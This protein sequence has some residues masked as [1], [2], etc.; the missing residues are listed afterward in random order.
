M[1]ISKRQ[2]LVDQ[3]KDLFMVSDRTRDLTLSRKV[4]LRKRVFLHGIGLGEG[5]QA[6]YR[7]HYHISLVR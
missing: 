7:R 3:W 1:R 5:M 4:L 2:R 6:G